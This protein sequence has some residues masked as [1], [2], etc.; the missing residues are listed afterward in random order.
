MEHRL[1]IYLNGHPSEYA[2]LLQ[3][4]TVDYQTIVSELLLLSDR[5]HIIDEALMDRMNLLYPLMIDH[6]ILH[7][8]TERQLILLLQECKQKIDAR[9]RPLS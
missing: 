6:T 1:W 7:H 3:E 9:F 2:S 8:E 4:E 5:L